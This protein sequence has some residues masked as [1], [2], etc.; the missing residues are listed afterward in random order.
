MLTLN[1]ISLPSVHPNGLRLWTQEI[2]LAR[3]GQFSSGSLPLAAAGT[4]PPAATGA[5]PPWNGLLIED[6]Q[7]VIRQEMQTMQL[8]PQIP[9]PGRSLITALALEHTVKQMEGGPRIWP[10]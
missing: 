8:W 2:E 5:L 4:L 3:V 10:S 7:G 1:L 9:A 6:V